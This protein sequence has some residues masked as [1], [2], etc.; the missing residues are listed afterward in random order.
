LELNSSSILVRDTTIVDNNGPGILVTNDGVPSIVNA[1]IIHNSG[2]GVIIS[3]GAR[4][5]FRGGSIFRNGAFGMRS[6][7][8][9]FVRNII[10]AE[11]IFWGDDG[12]P[13]DSSDD[14]GA[15]PPGLFNPA[16]QGSAVSDCIDYDPPTRLGPSIEGT[17]AA[18]SGGGQSGT[19][20]SLLPA[21]LCV[22]VR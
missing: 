14:T 16:G 15:Q 22:E 1:T 5:T 4:P 3:S 10:S 8:C 13:L 19:P 11:H 18:F 2:D 21:P 12:G 20:G 17:L 9:P 6:E 7:D